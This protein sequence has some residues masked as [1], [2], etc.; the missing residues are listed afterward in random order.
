ML[1]RSRGLEPFL[2][3]E[4]WEEPQF[5]SRFGGSGVAALDWPPM[6]EVGGQVRVYRPSDR[7]RYRTG[8]N[9][10]TEYVR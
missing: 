2:L 7:E 5:R 6:A 8:G 3:F 10:R 1:F 9:V 4:R